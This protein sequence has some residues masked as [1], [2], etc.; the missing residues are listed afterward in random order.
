MLKAKDDRIFQNVWDR[1]GVELA[2]K[3]L[4]FAK[5]LGCE[6]DGLC[7]KQKMVEFFKTFGMRIQVASIRPKGGGIF[8][9]VCDENKTGSD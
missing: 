2:Q 1:K 9:N 3:A 8:R 7:L 4:D 5:R 6:Y